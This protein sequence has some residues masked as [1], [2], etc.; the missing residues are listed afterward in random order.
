M[1]DGVTARVVCHREG[2]RFR[3]G[4]LGAETL[5]LDRDAAGRGRL[6]GDPEL[7]HVGEGVDGLAALAEWGG[8]Q[9]GG[10]VGDAGADAGGHVARLL[11]R[12]RIGAAAAAAAQGGERLQLRQCRLR[13][14]HPVVDGAA[15]VAVHFQDRGHLEAGAGRDRA[16][17]KKSRAEG[18]KSRPHGSKMTQ[19]R[20]SPAR[21]SPC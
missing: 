15:A 4:R 17:D 1:Q 2:D 11:F 21:I 7:A 8:D 10:R 13:V 18:E 19:I 6:R 12:E 14:D 16:T 3:G 9:F 20:A 5:R